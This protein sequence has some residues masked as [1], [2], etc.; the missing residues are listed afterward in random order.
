MRCVCVVS[1]TR[2]RMIC[3]VTGAMEQ[4]ISDAAQSR[5][6]EIKPP[7]EKPVECTRLLSTYGKATIPR[8]K[9]TSFASSVLGTQLLLPIGA[10]G[11][12]TMY[13]AA[14]P[15]ARK[16]V[17]AF[18]VFAVMVWPWMSMITP[19]L[20]TAEQPVAGPCIVNPMPL[21][22]TVAGTIVGTAVSTHCE[23]DRVLH[24]ANTASRRPLIMLHHFKFRG[25]CY[26]NP[27]KPLV[28]WLLRNGGGCAS[29][30]A[31]LVIIS[32]RTQKNTLSPT[33]S[34]LR[35]C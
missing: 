34:P 4:M 22:T 14:V 27:P 12:T 33:P 35:R 7:W 9:A 2:K 5:D 6:Q 26:K 31:Q 23:D 30:C 16:L 24:A 18:S 28:S 13:P 3:V 1:S 8:R 10:V 32:N 20:C 25:F 11:C 21:H 29:V 19:H 15:R 17:L